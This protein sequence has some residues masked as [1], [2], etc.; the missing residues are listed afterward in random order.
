MRVAATSRA[1]VAAAAAEALG[2]IHARVVPG[3]FAATRIDTA[4]SVA[5]LG[6]AAIW[7]LVHNQARTRSGLTAFI[8]EFDR[9]L[10]AAF[11]PTHRAAVLKANRN[12]DSFA[13][14]AV[15]A[16]RRS[17]WFEARILHKSAVGAVLLRDRHT[18]V[19]PRDVAARGLGRA[20][21]SAA[22]RVAASAGKEV[23]GKA[24]V[25]RVAAGVLGRGARSRRE[26]RPRNCDEQHQTAD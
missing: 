6:V 12:A 24:V 8:G 20:N 5:A 16:R 11:I 18:D 4:N 9:L 17:V 25:G 19:V 13:N 10:D 26:R 7:V 22:H 15:V 1:R 21:E 3:L 23:G 2:P 14:R